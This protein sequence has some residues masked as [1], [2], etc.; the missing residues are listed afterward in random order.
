MIGSAEVTVTSRTPIPSLSQFIDFFHEAVEE[1]KVLGRVREIEILFHDPS[2][3]DST[4]L[5]GTI[6]GEVRNIVHTTAA[7]IESGFV[8]VGIVFRR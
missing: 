3:G 5:I 1:C 2:S 4:Q 7:H 6:P 8:V